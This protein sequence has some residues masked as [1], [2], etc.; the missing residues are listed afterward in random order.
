MNAINHGFTVKSKA[1]KI[2]IKATTTMAATTIR[3]A[4]T[5]L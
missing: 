2:T 3:N 4:N 5:E 1:I